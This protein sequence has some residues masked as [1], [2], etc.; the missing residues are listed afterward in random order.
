MCPPGDV[1]AFEGTLCYT[2]SAAEGTYTERRATELFTYTRK[3]LGFRIQQLNCGLVGA[4]SN[5]AQRRTRYDS[6][7]GRY[8]VQDRLVASQCVSQLTVAAGTQ[9]ASL[10]TLRLVTAIGDDARQVEKRRERKNAPR[11]TSQNVLL[12]RGRRGWGAPSCQQSGACG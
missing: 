7:G 12:R 11:S 8:V 6:A 5:A 9:A 3:Q 2:Y 1:V 10:S 4:D